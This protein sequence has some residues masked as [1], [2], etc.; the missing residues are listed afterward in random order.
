M[1]KLSVLWR[2]LRGALGAAPADDELAAELESH[3]QMHTDDNLRSGMTPEQARRHAILKLGGLEQ[4]KQA[5]RERNTIPFIEALLAD[6]RY[7][8][9]Q[10]LR[11]P[12]FA[13]TAVLLITIG[14]G[15]NAA[16]FTLVEYGRCLFRSRNA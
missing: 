13:M 4:T 2:R 12:G 8:W 14:I 5:Y 15:A 6:V 3:L 10:L 1:L 7:A 11:S 9:R 16:I